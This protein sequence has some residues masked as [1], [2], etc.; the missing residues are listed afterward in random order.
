M[1]SSRAGDLVHRQ[2]PSVCRR[3]QR[4]HRKDD[5]FGQRMVGTNEDSVQQVHSRPWSQITGVRGLVSI[6]WAMS[7]APFAP[8]P[9]EAA[10]KEQNLRK[11]RLETPC[12]RIN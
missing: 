6:A 1:T 12:R 4:N 7:A 5:V 10:V 9:R 3:R 11:L 8:S 2:R